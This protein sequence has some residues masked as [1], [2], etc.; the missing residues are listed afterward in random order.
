MK[1]IYFDGCF[2]WLHAPA[3]TGEAAPS[4]GVVLCSTFAQEE[5]CTHYGMMALAEELA[6]M[7]LPT[8]RFDY[9]G[10]GDSSGTGDDVTFPGMV[11]DAERAA[12]CL[13]AHCNVG[14]VALAGVRLADGA[15]AERPGLSA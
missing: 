3:V 9:R 8:V 7:G 6:A 5:V 14:T 12:A 15:C 11:G 4:V 10:T 1:P 13:R 2:G